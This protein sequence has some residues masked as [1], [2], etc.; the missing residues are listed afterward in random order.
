MEKT[1]IQLPALSNELR[2]E[3]RVIGDK[4]FVV[5]QDCFNA[6][7]EVLAR[8]M[9]VNLLGPFILNALDLHIRYFK[10]RPHYR[11][12]W[13][14]AIGASII[15]T[16]AKL[17]EAFMDRKD[18]YTDLCEVVNRRLAPDDKTWRIDIPS[19]LSLWQGQ[20]PA[21]PEDALNA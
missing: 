1:P 6:E 12:E 21:H 11:L 3:L 4:S 13:Q 15:E 5:L 20:S 2:A 9:A 18:F 10:R 17:I 19:Y 16:F 14:S 7:E 8:L